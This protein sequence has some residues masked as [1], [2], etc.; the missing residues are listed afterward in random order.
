MIGQ[1]LCLA[2][3][4]RP[5]AAAAVILAC[6]SLNAATGAAEPIAK[7]DVFG[8]AEISFVGPAQRPGDTPA[9]DVQFS[10]VFQHED[11]RTEHM[12]HGFFDGDGKGGVA[13][14]VFKVRFCPTRPGRWELSEVKSSDAKLSGQRKGE[15]VLAESARR[16]G[17]WEVDAGSP[18]QRLYKR[19]D[20]S[21]DYVIG[22]TQYSF[23]SGRRE[24]DRPS[25][26]DIA[27]DVAANARYFKKLR[28]ALHGDRY[29]NPDAK[30]FLDDNGRPTDSGDY[31]HRPN[32]AWFHQRAD[33]AV[34]AAMEND[35]I[36]DLILAGPDTED[37]RATLRAGKNDGDATPWL[38]YIA[39]RY[40]SYPNVWICL[41]NEYNIKKPVF[42]ERQIAG[43]GQIIRKLLPYPTPLSVHACPPLV[44][45]DAFDSLPAWN[46]H[47]I[48]QKKL[49]RLGPAADV[50]VEAWKGASGSPRNKPTINDELSYQGAG[51]K[52]S[53]GDTIESHLGAFL[54]GG[55]ASTGYK[56]GNKLGHYFYGGF[57]PKEHTAAD[58]LRYMRQVIDDGITFWK[59]SPDDRIFENLDAGFRGL[60]WDGEEYV[61]GTNKSRRGITARL[62]AGQWTVARHDVI[63][64][65]SDVLTNSAAG[66]YRFD[67]PDSRA[68]LFHFRKS[69]EQARSEP[70]ERA[71]E[72]ETAAFPLKVS[73][74]R[75]CLVDQRGRPFFFHADT[76]WQLPKRLKREEVERYLDDRKG[77]GF[78]A[79]LVQSFS[80]E[81][82]PLPNAYGDIPFDKSENIL[83]PNEAYWR[84]VDFVIEQAAR[85]GL[86]VAMAPLW[87]RWGGDDKQGWRNHLTDDNARPYGEF[88]GRRYARH[89]NLLWILG[90]DAN[91]KEKTAAIRLIAQGIKAHAPKQLIMVHN[92]PEH[93]SAKFFGD[94]DWLD[95]NMAYSYKEV[96]P[97]ILGEWTAMGRVRPILLGESGY[98]EESND[99]RG[100]SPWRMRRQAYEAILAGGLGG[101]AFGQKHIWR[102]DDEWRQALDSP[103]S[104]QMTRV[105]NLFASRPW[106]L[107]EPDHANLLVVEGQGKKGEV[108]YVVAAR[109][110][111]GS[112]ALLYF[113]TTLTVKL[114]LAN[115]GA[116]PK[117]Q[118]YDPTNGKSQAI[119]DFASADSRTAIVTPPAKN[120]AG[121]PDWVLV[122]EATK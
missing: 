94:D 117:A 102:F 29:V 75:R 118:W 115:L 4:G 89:E 69:K 71:A 93:P 82:T 26:V 36:A 35:L 104:R 34:K 67:A 79:I 73:E 58:G 27:A 90:G 80:K 83:K 121:D 92:A 62:P 19:S 78:T 63:A 113:P 6:L 88:V 106:H 28:F 30:P 39:A 23:L 54:G 44:W 74:N 107:L 31:S 114:N 7:V 109:A 96:Y 57:N 61:L 40:G 49:R 2:H 95:I 110:S 38:R 68:V 50:T 8:V 98:E 86:A 32:P 47:Q 46:D 33:V 22:N 9:R 41:C 11:G 12:I 97:Q 91:P 122:L 21:H 3:Q 66:E 42:A 14:D 64:R 84:Q 56:P 17:F 15:F 48:V 59:M 120:S 101:H 43:F 16:R 25:G 77:R 24:G 105:K 5:R 76:A 108:E 85:R 70:S 103:G 116:S 53:E 37:S 51:D 111:D 10:A 52:H 100:G 87:I 60:A 13:G 55:Y 119:A 81:V 20:G 65:K 1:L 18:G 99:K 112:L 72:A 45:S